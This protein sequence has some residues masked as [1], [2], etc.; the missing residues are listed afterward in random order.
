MRVYT[1]FGLAEGLSGQQRVQ[2]VAILLGIVVF[3]AIVLVV[4]RRN[5]HHEAVPPGVTA[6]L[7]ALDPPRQV[8]R[9]PAT[10]IPIASARETAD[11]LR[12]PEPYPVPFLA[13]VEGHE[14][15][16]PP[17]VSG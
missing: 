17:P 11:R 15:P 2:L 13:E 3:I 1:V 8:R 14:P 10:A 5:A 7:A 16:E 9:P 6:G 12:T 4:E